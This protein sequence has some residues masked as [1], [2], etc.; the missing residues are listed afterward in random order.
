MQRLSG[1]R[2]ILLLED[3]I[4]LALTN[5]GEVYGWGRGEHGRLGFGNDKSSI[6]VPQGSTSRR[7][8]Y[9]SEIGFAAVSCGGTHSVAFMRDGR[10]FSF[11][12]GDH[13]TSGHPSEVPINL[14]PPKNLSG[15]EADGRWCAELVAC[16]GRHT[17]AIVEWH[18]DES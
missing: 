9:Y 11:G 17:L 6:M 18:S 10:M 12:R 3:G 1:V 15:G 4:L 8:R 2:L 14:P 16:G 7:G 5:D 13:G